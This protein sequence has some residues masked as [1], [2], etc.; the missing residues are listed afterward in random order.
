M[1]TE[2]IDKRKEDIAIWRPK[3]KRKKIEKKIDRI[4]GLTLTHSDF[5]L[6]THASARDTVVWT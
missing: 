3:T 1:K 5:K 4:S 6:L 2:K